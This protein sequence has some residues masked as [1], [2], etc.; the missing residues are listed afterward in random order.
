[1]G[2]VQGN[3]P[4][5][6]TGEQIEI[7]K[8]E[9]ATAMAGQQWRRALQFCSWL[10]YALRQQGLSDPEVEQVQRRAKE[11]LA[12]KVIKEKPQPAAPSVAPSSLF[13]TV[14]K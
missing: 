11:A 1:V 5:T 9:L 7:W 4:K 8:K 14:S 13:H 12:E 2:G 10:R 6:T 3:V